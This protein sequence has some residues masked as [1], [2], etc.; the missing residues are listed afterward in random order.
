MEQ[1]KLVRYALDQRV[2]C[3]LVVGQTVHSLASELWARP[4]IG[5]PELPSM[6]WSF[7]H[8]ACQPRS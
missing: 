1:V 7:C 4:R 3:G 6:R 8:P 2:A 5:A